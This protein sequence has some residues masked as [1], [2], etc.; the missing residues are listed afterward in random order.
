[1][2]VDR[3]TLR[4]ILDVEWEMFHSV[5][6]I[7][8]PAACQQ[9]RKTFELMRSSQLQAWNEEVARSYLDDLAAARAAGRNLMTEK[10]ARMMEYTSPCEYRRI[11]AE[12]PALDPVAP[13][14]IERLTELSVRWMEEVAA[15]YPYVGAQGRPLR[16]SGDSVATPSFETYNRGELAT[17]SLKTLQLL[18]E[19]YLKMD[20]EG[21]NAAE[22]ILRHT[23]EQYGYASLEQAEA[24]QKAR[25]DKERA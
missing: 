24:A 2:T 7:D 22:V 12:L 4:R 18:Q 9:D 5:Q 13:P 17:Y 21:E 19:H 6:G 20:A 15:K 3:E 1:M 25:R 16:N 11:A 14:I 23:V 8:G 10:Y